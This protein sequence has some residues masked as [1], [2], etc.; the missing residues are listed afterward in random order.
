[1]FRVAAYPPGFASSDFKFKAVVYLKRLRSLEWSS[2]GLRINVGILV[3]LLP[4]ARQRT[5][6][7][8]RRLLVPF[9]HQLPCKEQEIWCACF[10]AS[11]EERMPVAL[12][13]PGQ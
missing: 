4:F 7:K 1:M 10:S 11:R 13:S 8:K 5:P 6:I 3:D 9:C 12:K 2:P